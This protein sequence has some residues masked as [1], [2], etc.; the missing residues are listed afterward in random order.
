MGVM[1]LPVESE[2]IQF[3]KNKMLINEF[4]ITDSDVVSFF[5]DFQGAPNELDQKFANALRVGV[6]ALRTSGVVNN[7]DYIEK[8]FTKF[9]TSIHQILDKMFGEDGTI[10]RTIEEH[11]GEGGRVHKV[12]EE[13]FGE[14]GKLQEII[15]DHFGERGKLIREIFDPNKEGTPLYQL[16]LA[17]EE[18]LSQIAREVAK[19][20]GAKEVEAKTTLKGSK[21]EDYFEQLLSKVV[22][23]SGGDILEPTSFA[24]GEMRHRKTGDFVVSFGNGY[25]SI[26]VETKDVKGYTVRKICEELNRAM[27]NRKCSYGI[28]VSKNVNS[29]HPSIGWINEYEGN[30]LICA[31]SSSDDDNG[32]IHE[33][34]LHIAYKW[35]KFKLSL[36]S[37][38]EEKKIDV[39]LIENKIKELRSDLTTFNAINT[40]CKDIDKSTDE[41]RSI[42]RILGNKMQTELNQII[43]ALNNS[44]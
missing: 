1:K 34:I 10:Q 8:E 28:L 40:K 29:L 11:F 41:I 23:A 44:K 26:V 31:L 24:T 15:D 37:A 21:F 36:A 32:L 2:N 5:K 33:E 12:I 19:K 13:H 16:R 17:M 35:A 39:T 25:G 18:K 3:T 6:I 7:V 14:D 38:R 22:K 27:E 9:G 20:E 4:E 43:L 42:I 30:K